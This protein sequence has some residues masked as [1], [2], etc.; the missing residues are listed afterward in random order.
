MIPKRHHEGLAVQFLRSN[1]VCINELNGGGTL[2]WPKTAKE[3]P[4]RPTD[5]FRLHQTVL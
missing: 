2:T 1:A 4:G 5:S 3:A